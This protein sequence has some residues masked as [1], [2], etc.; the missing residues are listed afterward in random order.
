MKAAGATESRQKQHKPA[1]AF[2]ANSS[3]ATRPLTPN[4]ALASSRS[5]S[6]KIDPMIRPENQ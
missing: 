4:L 3:S 6:Q 1:A 5:R 2:R